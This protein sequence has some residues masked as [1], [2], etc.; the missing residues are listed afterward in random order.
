MTTEKDV[1]DCVRELMVI[2]RKFVVHPGPNNGGYH[3]ANEASWAISNAFQG[4]A[5][6]EEYRSA[7][8]KQSASRKKQ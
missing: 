1:L 6:T 4:L 7:M 2:N 3:E 8:E 5:S